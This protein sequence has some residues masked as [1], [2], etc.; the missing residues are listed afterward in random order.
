[1]LPTTE[2]VV[3]MSRLPTQPRIAIIAD[4]LTSAADG[5]A[6]F[7]RRGM[8]SIITL[9]PEATVT[10]R[11]EIIAAG[12]TVVSVDV[13]SRRL[14]AG[15]AARRTY[16]AVQ[17]LRDVELIYKTIDSTL[18][19]NIASE[20]SAALAASGR[21][22]AVV[23][24]AF[25]A[26][27]RTT[28]A[29]IQYLDGIPVHLTATSDDSIDRAEASN[30]LKILPSSA[31]LAGRDV[32]KLNG[33]VVAD[34]QTQADLNYLVDSVRDRHRVLWV[35]SPGIAHALAG[36]AIGSSHP[37]PSWPVSR[38]I[39][40]V[41]GSRNPASHAQLAALLDSA[42]TALHDIV[43]GNDTS[44]LEHQLATNGVG[45]L[46]DSSSGFSA[47]QA[48]RRLAAVVTRLRRADAIDAMV[49]TG[50][51]TA[52]AILDALDITALDL[53]SEF[54]PGVV[55]AVTSGQSGFP[56]A[57]KAG[58]FGDPLT[59]VRMTRQLTVETEGLI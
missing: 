39:L 43:C 49:V 32:A 37:A 26:Q 34:A 40:T 1:M 17:R 51:A 5:A 36:S 54:E 46:I 13:N 21:A 50:G 7:A 47:D 11:P 27:G 31:A 28:Q 38:R 20:I 48:G 15:Q 2:R 33:I 42:P 22:V 44:E 41:V 25:P 24:P 6:P 57:V 35:G 58:G 45:A 10:L 59:L 19:G 52:R 55:L 23:A 4:D 8:R 56:I 18:R 30:L 16:T 14:T 12:A 53:V 29:G 3:A 9:A